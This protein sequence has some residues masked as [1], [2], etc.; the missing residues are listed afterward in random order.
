EFNIDVNRIAVGGDSAG[1][2]LSAVTSIKAKE[3]GGPKLVHQFLLYP[4]TGYKGDLPK[5]MVENGE[6]YFLTIEMMRWFTNHYFNNPE[7]VQDPYASPIHFPDLSGLPPATLLTAEYDT[8]RDE[9]KAYGEALKESGVDVFYKNYEDLIHGFANFI[10]FSPESKAAL[11]EGA[12]KLREV[13]Y[14]KV[15]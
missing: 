2:N 15:K 3:K 9:G 10:T 11:Q 14:T 7:E 6:G 4:A 8:L 1:G 12:E 13:F 5:S